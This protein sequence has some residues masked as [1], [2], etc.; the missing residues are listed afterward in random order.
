MSLSAKLA[1]FIVDTKYEDLPHD[2]VEFT[3]LC[4]LDW[5]SSAIAG[6]VKPSVQMV[7]QLAKELGGFEQATLVTGGRTSVANAALVNGA[8]SHVVELDDIHKGSII[9]AA[10]V[11]VPAALAVAEWMGKS[12]KDLITAVA[13]GYDVCFRIG[14][15]VSPSHYYYWH[16]TATCG[17]FG[18]AA[19]VAKLLELDEKQIVH[20]LGN[21]G[22]Q[23]AGLWE[24]IVD[25]AMSK[26]LHTAKAAMNGLL[27]SLLAQK[28]F[29]G[30]SKILEGDR[31][32]FK[33]MSESY[34]E[35]RI[36]N[37]LGERFKITE[38]SFKIHASC[39]H[40]HP[41][42]DLIIRAKKEHS[43][44]PSDIRKI[45]VGGYQS[46]IN[47]TDNP[48]PQTVYAAKFSLQYC[49]SLALVKGKA[50]L[51]D[52]TEES[53]W[54]PEIRSLIPKVELT[55]DSA[56]NDAYPEKWG[57]V[58]EIE[59]QDG[60]RIQLSTEYPKGDPE[61]PVTADDL[62]AKF[63]ELAAELSEEQINRYVETVLSLEK[64]ESAADF[65]KAATLV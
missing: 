6:S 36:T 5:L 45:H 65:W 42:V 14:E 53:L 63:R 10:T 22:T 1:R 54:D 55:L 12:G 7:D 60:K 27:A 3:K 21:A 2:V 20:A 64:V 49:V 16:N 31:G 29:T 18:S 46:V 11:V 56:V 28:G 38:N 25:G 37:G 35:T 9:H 26:Q 8:A 4:I 62:V 40:T 24:F 15:A 13:V 50:G 30:P 19:A 58:V 61:H 44:Q 41:A 57:S 59:T 32:F 33:A 43:L 52:F 47:I 17:T 23:A 34:D 48:N 39:R 51:P